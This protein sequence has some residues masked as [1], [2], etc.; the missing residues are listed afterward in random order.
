MRTISL[1]SS[2][3]SKTVPWPSVTGNSGLPGRG[4]VATTVL[5]FGVDDGDVVGA[6]V[7]GPDGLR[8]RLKEDVVRAGS[9]GDGSDDGEGGAVECNYRVAAAVGDVAELAGGV[10]RDGVDAVEIGDGADGFAGVGVDNIDLSAVGDVKAMRAGIGDRIV[11]AAIA[12]DFPVVDDVVGLLRHGGCGR[13]AAGCCAARRVWH[14]GEAMMAAMRERCRRDMRNSGRDIGRG[15][16]ST[17]GVDE[18][19]KAR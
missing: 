10:E 4:M 1:L 5:R 15:K 2:M 16:D 3:L 17:R 12:A 8:D 19:I 14:C 13:G 9:G 7:E 11:P 6:A 18:A